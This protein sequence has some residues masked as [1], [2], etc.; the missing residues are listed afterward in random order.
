MIRRLT[1]F[2]VGTANLALIWLTWK[3]FR[4][5]LDWN[6]AY[7]ALAISGFWLVLTVGLGALSTIAWADSRLGEV[8]SPHAIAVVVLVLCFAGIVSLSK[9]R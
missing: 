6:L 9:K 8:A 7:G 2:A 4:G 1:K 3:F 5:E